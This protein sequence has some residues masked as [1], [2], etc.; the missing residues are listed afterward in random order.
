[1][2]KILALIPILIVAGVAI[3]NPVLPKEEVK[4]DAAQKQEVVL[5]KSD[6]GTGW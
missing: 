3:L 6:P 2:K 4:Q 1:M 5:Y